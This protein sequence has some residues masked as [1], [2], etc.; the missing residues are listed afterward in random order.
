MKTVMI[1]PGSARFDG[2]TEFEWASPAPGSTHRFLLFFAQDESVSKLGLALQEVARYGFRDIELGEGRPI[3]VESLNDPA[4]AA[5]R[6]H[7]E[8]AFSEESSLVW[9]P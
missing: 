7:Y 6:K 9:Y 5:F 1:Y 4:M 8:G 2:K 3:D